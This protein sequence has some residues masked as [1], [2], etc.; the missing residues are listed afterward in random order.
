MDRF[1]AIQTFRAVAAHGGFAAAARA[2]NT[3]PPSVSRLIVRIIGK[4]DEL[5]VRLVDSTA[6]PEALH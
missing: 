1:Q 2:L 5:G 4:P 3:S 6:T